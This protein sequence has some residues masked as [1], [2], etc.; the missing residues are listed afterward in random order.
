MKL[1][2]KGASQWARLADKFMNFLESSLSK[3]ISMLDCSWDS[4]NGR[5]GTLTEQNYNVHNV[6]ASGDLIS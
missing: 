6:G 2:S 3:F 1:V 4:M 5:T